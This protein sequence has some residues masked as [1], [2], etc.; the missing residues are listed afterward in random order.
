MKKVGC[1]TFHASYNFGSNLQAYALQE[2]VKKLSDDIDYKIINF[3]S[4]NQKKLYDYGCSR[5][6]LKFLF[7][8]KLLERQEKFE[9]F[10]NKKLNL[11]EKEYNNN[12]ELQKEEFKFDYYISG[13]DQIWNLS[14]RDFDWSYYLDFVKKGKKISYAASRGP[15][16]REISTENLQTIK[17]LVSKY[18]N[19]S[20]REQGTFEFIKKL[21]DKNIDINLDPTLLLTREEWQK[22]LDGH[23]KIIDKPYILYYS[24]K[25]S[26]VR[27]KLLKHLGKVMN[28]K[29]VVANPY[30]KYDLVGGFKKNYNSGPIEFLN[31]LANADLVVSS[32]FHGTVFS[33]LFNK[34]FYTLNGKNDFRISTLL[35]ITGLENRAITEESDIKELVN[36]ASKIS[37]EQANTQLEIEREKSKKYL[38]KALDIGE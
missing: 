32:S 6:R 8:K 15:V 17:G 34:P 14:A 7:K 5:S 28:K 12:E 37:F 23:K 24:L 20:V 35:N 38:L 31:L 19:I 30:I 13:S 9:N 3:R 10:I 4:E 21:T 36:N 11:T 29:V 1:I 26:K 2:Y 27:S 16:N 18:D 22:L 25:P 33:I